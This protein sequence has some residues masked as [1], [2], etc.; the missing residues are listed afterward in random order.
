MPKMLRH[1]DGISSRKRRSYM[2]LPQAKVA[3]WTVR[4]CPAAKA[5]RRV[6]FSQLQAANSV[7]RGRIQ[8]CDRFDN[9]ISRCRTRPVA[10]GERRRLQDASGGFD[11]QMADGTRIYMPFL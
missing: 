11:P 6:S 4:E 2:C 7:A 5:V 8:V 9:G 3:A 10:D 1:R